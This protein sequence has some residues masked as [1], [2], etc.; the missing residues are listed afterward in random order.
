MTLE[1]NF[2]M[3]DSFPIICNPRALY[4]LIDCWPIE[5]YIPASFRNPSSAAPRP[6][7]LVQNYDWAL[8]GPKDIDLNM[9]FQNQTNYS[10][11]WFFKSSE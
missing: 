1:M 6:K 8:E 9:R 5:N 4:N 2:W 7:V 3:S 10:E 11:N